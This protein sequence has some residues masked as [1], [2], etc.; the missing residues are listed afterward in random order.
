MSKS[1]SR[2]DTLAARQA[3][4]VIEHD[5]RP[6]FII[7][8]DEVGYGAWAGPLVVGGA[9]TP[10]GWHASWVKDSKQLKENRRVEAAA[11]LKELGIVTMTRECAAARIDEEKVVNSLRRLNQELVT[12]LVETL[13]VT[14]TYVL[15]MD[16]NTPHLPRNTSFK[17]VFCPKADACV[18][19]VSA[20]SI[21]AKVTRD[22]YMVEYAKWYPQYDWENNKGYG[23]QKHYE[24]LLQHGPCALHRMT[25]SSIGEICRQRKSRETQPST[26]LSPLPNNGGTCNVVDWKT[27]SR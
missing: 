20:A 17:P 21:V 3:L 26:S 18:P 4:Y 13:P 25:Y 23:T 16:G 15:F 5:V 9:I 1:T 2:A 10:C 24:G 11:K 8:V 7:G 27:R 22:E 6:D 19:A 12:L 14:A